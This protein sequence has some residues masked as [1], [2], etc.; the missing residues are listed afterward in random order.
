MQ[1]AGYGEK[2]LTMIRGVESVQE[3]LE[4]AEPQE[5]RSSKSGKMEKGYA[6]ET[7]IGNS[8]PSSW[9]ALT[10]IQVEA[11]PQGEKKWGRKSP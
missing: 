1:D 3:V 10:K 5:G 11:M 2:Y 4:T 9:R 7:E 6:E 8:G